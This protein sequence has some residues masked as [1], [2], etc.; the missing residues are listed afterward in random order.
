MTALARGLSVLRCFSHDRPELGAQDIVR[1]TGLPQPTVWRLCHTLSREGLL[2]CDA[3]SGRM[4][5]GLPA[6]ALGY[7]ALA[8][9][10]LPQAALPYL[11]SL[12]KRH[13][14]GLSLAVR[15]GLSMLYLQRTHGDFIYFNDPVGAR[16]PLAL[17]PTGWAC[18][19]AYDESER[20]R[21]LA[22][23]QRE[24]P[25]AWPLTQARLQ[26]AGE[27]YRRH[28]CILSLGVLHEHLHAVA[29][30]I[31]SRTSA[32][33]YG[34]SAAGVAAQWPKKKLLAVGAELVTLA[35]ELSVVAD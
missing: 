10:T 30:P 18:L 21:V 34:L 9:R 31:R 4:T 23:L 13:R 27:Q 6:L 19:F 20:E 2:L 29:V 22:A 17:A 26:A 16:R 24:N 11:Q 15:D 12:T 8:R 14:L 1:M 25:A 32:Q 5:V 7:A 35:R 28:G 3:E 33:V